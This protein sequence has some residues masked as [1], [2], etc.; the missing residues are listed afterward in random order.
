MLSK[1]R[2]DF[3]KRRLLT[4]SNTACFYAFDKRKLGLTITNETHHFK[5]RLGIFSLSL[6]ISAHNSYSRTEEVTVILD[7]IYVLQFLRKFGSSPF[8]DGRIFRTTPRTLAQ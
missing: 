7:H 4:M 5:F 3:N 6:N 2:S 8:P 1:S